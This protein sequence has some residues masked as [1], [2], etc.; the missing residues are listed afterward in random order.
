M[1]N[2]IEQFNLTTVARAHVTVAPKKLEAIVIYNQLADGSRDPAAEHADC[3]VIEVIF[4]ICY[5]NAKAQQI[6]ITPSVSCMFGQGEKWIA[7]LFIWNGPRAGSWTING[8]TGERERPNL[9]S[10]S[11]SFEAREVER[12][13]LYWEGSV[14]NRSDTDCVD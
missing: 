5:I 13:V 8:F 14:I 11:V 4:L 12:A 3:P 9:V 7:K 1:L 10:V 2:P 6:T